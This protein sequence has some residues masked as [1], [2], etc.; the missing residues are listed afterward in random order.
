MNRTKSFFRAIY[1]IILYFF[2]T[3]KIT[4]NIIPIL[5]K[6]LGFILELMKRMFYSLWGQF[7]KLF[8]FSLTFKITFVYGIII[9][10][11]L[12][13]SS[14][15]IFLGFRFFLIYEAKE[16]LKKNSSIIMEYLLENV[17]IPTT[18][19]MKISKYAN[20]VTTLFDEDNKLIYSSDDNNKNLS[21]YENSNTPSII[22]NANGD[23][24]VLSKE[25]YLNTNKLYL[26]LSKSLVHENTFINILFTALLAVNIIS[27]IIIII[28][29]FKLSKKM[30]SPIKDM[31]ETAKAI[32]VN[33]L[34]TRLDV[35]GA[36]DELRDLAVTFNEMFDRIQQSYE[37]QNQFVSDASHELRTPISVI[38]GYINLLDR[39][40]KGDEE[41]LDES[42]DAIKG[43]SQA[44]KDLIEKLLFLA[45]SDKN[46]LQ[47]QIEYFHINALI[48]E[49]T[50]ETN[51]IDTKHE[52]V[53]EVN[54][55]VLISADRKLL[56]QAM[57]IFIDNSVKFT[58]IGG[59]IK[60]GAY[61][62]KR[63]LMIIVEDTGAGIPKEDIPLIF[64]RFYRSDKSRTKETGGHG[65][66]LSIARWIID[67]HNG[68]IKV[69][70][71]V[72]VGTKI[73][74]FLPYK[75]NNSSVTS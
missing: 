32:N 56:K 22:K 52:I 51:L 25:V 66:G 10:L 65:L 38:Q 11:I 13:L 63:R 46:L 4:I 53:S 55:D 59:M 47:L 16:E 12:F 15:I 60:I 44:M 72:D 73:K 6:L 36:Y 67:K 31:T 5:F 23:I 28:V 41:V 30:L 17:E 14:T 34:D 26:Q 42:I 19:I 58:P 74:V 1:K 43:E 2:T 49:I 24:L 18:K 48:E 7:K 57:R 39:W 50:Y 29:G 37:K 54:E 27:I 40:G 9:S 35:S 75:Q 64:N 21:L 61:P 20:F 8:R 45:R 70:S 33:R 71:Q 3:L 62:Q 68:N 69:E